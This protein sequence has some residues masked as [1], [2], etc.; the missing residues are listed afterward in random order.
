M[1]NR[2]AT[3]RDTWAKVAKQGGASGGQKGG[4]RRGKKSGKK[5]G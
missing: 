1:V 3:L 4:Q 5:R 2:T